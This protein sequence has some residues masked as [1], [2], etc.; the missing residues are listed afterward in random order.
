[1]KKNFL[2][3]NLFWDGE[4]YRWPNKAIASWV[5]EFISTGIRLRRR[6][7]GADELGPMASPPDDLVLT[8]LKKYRMFGHTY[9]N[10]KATWTP[11]P[12]E[13]CVRS[14]E[15]VLRQVGIAEGED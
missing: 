14:Y 5:I 9:C 15:V 12:S 4:K 3:F 7:A 10:I 8:E 6:A 2:G 1:M 11:R 13:E